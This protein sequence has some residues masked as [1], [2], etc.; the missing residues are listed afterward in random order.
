MAVT[1]YRMVVQI[2]MSGTTENASGL[3][4]SD[5]SGLLSEVIFAAYFPARH[6]L[7]EQTVKLSEGDGNVVVDRSQGTV[8]VPLA[9]DAFTAIHLSPNRTRKGQVSVYS[10]S[11]ASERLPTLDGQITLIGSVANATS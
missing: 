5:A 2:G 3:Q 6:G 1:N 9:A 10:E 7:P 4:L 8:S 11:S